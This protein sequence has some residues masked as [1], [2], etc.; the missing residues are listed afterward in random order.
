MDISDIYV[1]DAQL[2]RVVEDL[3]AATVTFEVE[4]AI[5]EREEQ[6]EPRHLVFDDSYNYQVFEQPWHGLVTI[7][8]MHVVSE[9]GRIRQVRIETNAG[10]GQLFCSGVRVVE[11][12]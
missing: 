4:L 11:S 7:L 2:H 12:H 8:D 3:E 5:L 1:H 9:E 6:M 10:Y